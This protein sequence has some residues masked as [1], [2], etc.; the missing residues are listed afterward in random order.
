MDVLNWNRFMKDRK[1][2][3]KIVERATKEVQ[4]G[5]KYLPL[6]WI[7]SKTLTYILLFSS[8]KDFFTICTFHVVCNKLIPIFKI[9]EIILLSTIFIVESS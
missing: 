8:F 2:W 5:L 4:P 3:E 9:T 1:T 6:W 7:T